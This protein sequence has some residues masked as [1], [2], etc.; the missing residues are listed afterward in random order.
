MKHKKEITLIAALS[1]AL[2]AAPATAK[3][4]KVPKE[5][6]GQKVV[7]L[8]WTKNVSGG[9]V[10]TVVRRASFRFPVKKPYPME[11]VPT[12][13]LNSHKKVITCRR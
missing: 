8:K 2:F 3:K 12:C 6:N 1:L 4:I 5:I 10:R 7:W 11:N 13:F 9:S